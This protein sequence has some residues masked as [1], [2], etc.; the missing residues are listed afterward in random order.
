[1]ILKNNWTTKTTASLG[2]I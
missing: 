1:L 2:L